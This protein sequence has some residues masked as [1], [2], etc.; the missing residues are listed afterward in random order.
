MGFS[1]GF[2]GRYYASPN[3]AS[4]WDDPES[5][6]PTEED[7]VMA[8]CGDEINGTNGF[9][10]H[11]ACWSLLEL[12][13]SPQPI[14]CEILFEVCRSLPSPLPYRSINW[15]HGFGGLNPEPF[16][17]CYPWEDKYAYE[18]ED[19]ATRGIAIRDPYHVPEIRRLLEEDPLGPVVKQVCT[20]ETTRADC[21]S[22]LPLELCIEIASYLPTADALKARRA[23]RSFQPIFYSQQ[24]WA[25]RFRPDGDRSW[26]FESRQLGEAQDWRWLCHRTNKSHVTDKPP[27]TKKYCSTRKAPC[28]KGINNRMRIWK[29]IGY[30][31]GILRR[32]WTESLLARPPATN[33]RWRGARWQEATGDIQS[34]CKLFGTFDNGCRLFHEQ[35]TLIPSSI[36]R[37]ILSIIQVGHFKFVSGMKLL[38]SQGRA[39][40]MG[41]MAD[42]QEV[43]P[44]TASL[45]GF[46]LVVGSRG[47][48]GIQCLG[49]DGWASE[50]FGC[51][52]GAPKTK[53]LAT[54]GPI[55]A[56]KAG[57]D[58]SNSRP[59]FVEVL[60]PPRYILSPFDPH[61]YLVVW[62]LMIAHGRDSKW[63]PWRLRQTQ[64]P[65][66][67]TRSRIA[68]RCEIRHSGIQTFPGLVYT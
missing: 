58:V 24:F 13:Y 19:G 55:K 32:R 65:P 67:E 53:R 51:L 12:A 56:I 22:P 8:F 35:E 14:P 29:L 30:V 38:P 61:S 42:R 50:W 1:G 40:E 43:V 18:K 11:E 39:V 45:F 64:H 28:G 63:Y 23:S 59:A 21:F 10:F 5:S 9:P 54:S 20:P 27:R 60:D 66:P 25:S 49:D 15:D 2:H 31:Q 7:S 57:F 48:Q 34:S 3:F 26:L 33:T 46:N 41:Y 37:I 6:I 44:S 52:V 16:R 68:N 17:Y 36:S 62:A 47:I 4:R